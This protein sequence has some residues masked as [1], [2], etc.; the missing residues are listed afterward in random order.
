MNWTDIFVKRPVLSI[1]VNLLILLIGIQSIR[2]LNV[3]QYPRSDSAAI[4][5]T[6]NYVGASAD[7]V[8][9]Y[10]TTPLEKAIASADGI[11]YLSSTSEQGVST[12]TVNLR[13]NYNPNDA[14]TQIQAKIAQVK[15]D[16]PPEAESPT[17]AVISKDT[18]FA[19]M[20]LSFSSDT[21]AEN[22]IT[23]YLLRVVQPK[24]TAIKGVQRADILGARY[25][26][27]RI[28][29]KPDRMSA[30][31]ISP[32]DV[33]TALKGNNALAAI[34]NTKSQMLQINLTANTDLHTREDF[35]KLVVKE[36][37]G[38]LVRLRDIA[39]VNL[40][41][42]DY[43]EE[44][45]FDGKKATFM[46]IYVLPTANALDVIKEVR[47]QIPAIAAQ[48]P[49]TLHVE[50][51][52]D[53]TRYINDSIHEV[54]H[55]LIETI[56]IVIVVIYLFIGSLR[57][58]LV[59][60]VA[61][62]LSLIGA[63]ALMSLFGFTIN[64][65]TL[66]AIVLAVGLVV[67][68]AIVMLENIERHVREGLSPRE[69]AIKGARELVV[70][71]ISMTITL[72]TV[73]APIAFQGGLTGALFREFALTLAGAV[74]ISGVV[75]LTLSPMMSGKL[76]RASYSPKGFQALLDRF[77][78]RLREAY[79][80]TL[81]TN[82]RIYPAIIVLAL[83][84]MTL[85]IPFYMF[86]KQES[87]PPE[88]QGVVLAIVMGPPGASVD[89]AKLSSD[90]IAKIFRGFP[91][92]ARIFQRITPSGGFGGMVTKPWSER[93]RSVQ[94]LLPEAFG[95]LSTVAGAQVIPFSPPPLPGGS[96]LP[97]EFY[98][99]S[100]AE[101]RE[102][103]A[104]AQDLVKTAFASGLYM[105][106]DT[107]L[108]FDQPQSEIVF[109]RDKVASLGLNLE[110]VISDLG[111]LTGG[112]YVNRFSIQNRS[113]KVIPEVKKMDRLT[114]DQ[115]TQLYVKGPGG[116]PIQLSSIA[117]VKNTTVPRQL[118]RFQQLN[119][120]KI[121][122]QLP[123]GVTIDQGLK[124]LE[125]E[126]QKILPPGFTY[127]Y[128]GQSRQLRVEG[129]ALMT[130]F[131]LATLL[132]FLV[133]AAQFES[134]RDPTIILLGSVPLALTGA[135][136]PIFMGWN[137]ATLNIYTQ[138][139]LITLVGL[140]SKN[141]ILIVEFANQLL[142]H[143]Y[144]K[145]DAI[146]EAASTRLRPVLMTTFATMIGH[147]P[148]IFVTGAGAAARNNIGIVLVMGMGIG[149]LFTLFVVP[150]FFLAIASDKKHLREP[151]PENTKN[152]SN[153]SHP[154]PSENPRVPLAS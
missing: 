139:G 74:V 68:D 117:T 52:Y 120:A 19:S 130:V 124:V 83:C 61:I 72:V 89:Q 112:N 53:A 30:L 60:V 11:D 33:V 6:T 15:N 129:N 70:P 104:F 22:Q 32:D 38:Q 31:G 151:D 107:D 143:G 121:Q 144:T 34:G 2:S 86:S 46:G 95:K 21:L 59:P 131:V 127:D 114:P 91:E 54:I 110:S 13:L 63:C 100:T 64:L 80:K 56:L 51:P 66:L 154:H 125:K 49:P 97:I 153:G 4:T 62:P 103:N 118:N 10:V 81:D 135:M 78:D 116:Q 69:A 87:A 35:E 102:L 119:S 142:L 41:A 42:E 106:A 40:G 108:K 94:Q 50:I 134:F 101:P 14:L 93:K 48:L 77:F 9:G 84:I 99:T 82:L 76:L 67:D 79:R 96:D 138:V 149:S 109:D 37:G 88:D 45:R 29:L 133:L 18:Q 39:D 8:K 150:A 113:Y 44:V 141:G 85:I 20:Y 105:Y 132:I 111:T 26:A 122:G 5:I 136:L 92:C 65:L 145:H 71:I 17:I 47:K 3:R 140:V 24:L 75:A 27:M 58:V 7:L 57:A 148:L 16:L 43:D 36:S 115:L 28:W 25:F 128:G 23:D 152:E 137:G 12:I 73:Y 55:T 1:C 126:A 146:I 147:T 98:I 123:P 90:Q